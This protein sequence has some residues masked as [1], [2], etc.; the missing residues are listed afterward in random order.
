MF[1]S[2]IEFIRD[3]YRSDEFIPLHA[4][5]FR[6]NERAY[7]NETLDSTF[8]SSVGGFV[9]RF[10]SD[11]QQYTGTARAVATVNGTAALHAAL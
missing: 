6:G 4:P 5:I 1:A 7:V 2:L 9:D 10:E 11:I 3:T 8:V